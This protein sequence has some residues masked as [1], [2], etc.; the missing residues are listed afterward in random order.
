MR[1]FKLSRREAACVQLILQ[2]RTNAEIAKELKT[3]QW[4]VKWYLKEIAERGSFNRSQVAAWHA[5][6]PFLT[7]LKAVGIEPTD[8]AKQII[9]A[10]T[11]RKRDG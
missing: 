1:K 6:Q 11:P 7:L 9:E 4:T 10:L 5:I 3:S 8:E 2:G